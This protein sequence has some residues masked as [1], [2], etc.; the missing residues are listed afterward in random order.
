MIP[1][2]DDNG[3]DIIIKIN[4]SILIAISILF[5]KHYSREYYGFREKYINCGERGSNT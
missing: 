2:R 4:N 5:E 3:I 1:Y